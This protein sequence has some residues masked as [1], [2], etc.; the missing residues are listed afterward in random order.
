MKLITDFEA[1]ASVDEN[2]LKEK[3]SSISKDIIAKAWIGTSP[4]NA[5]FLSSIFTDV[6]FEKERESIGR[7]KIEEV[8]AA[9]QEVLRILNQR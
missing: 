3:A 6:D 8:E 7:I 1:I 5:A 9:Q 2:I 4:V